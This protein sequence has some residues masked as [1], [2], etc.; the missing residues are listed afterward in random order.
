MLILLKI[1]IIHLNLINLRKT[2][3]I[4]AVIAITINTLISIIDFWIAINVVL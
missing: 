2:V 3:T 1:N 4:S